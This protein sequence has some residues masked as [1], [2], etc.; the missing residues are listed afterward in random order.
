[1]LT[2]KQLEQHTKEE[3]EILTI[4]ITIFKM[5]HRIYTEKQGKEW[6]KAREL[7]STLAKETLWKNIKI[8]CI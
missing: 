4:Y 2:E 5:S 1:M 3:I 7:S 6:V 8:Y